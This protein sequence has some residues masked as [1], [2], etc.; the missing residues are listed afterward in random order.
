MNSG[1][2]NPK[3]IGAHNI[4]AQNDRA[5][6]EQ[7]NRV[8]CKLATYLDLI[9]P[10]FAT[11]KETPCHKAYLVISNEVMRQQK[12]GAQKEKKLPKRE[13]IVM[14]HSKEKETDN[15]KL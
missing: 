3:I 13:L 10:M 14:F 11:L 8:L 2:T 6:W 5:V 7:Q 1:N 12:E 9:Q 15:I 4:L